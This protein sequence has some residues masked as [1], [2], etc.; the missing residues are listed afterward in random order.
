MDCIH[1]LAECEECGGLK[2]TTWTKLGD[3]ATVQ[4]DGGFTLGPGAVYIAPVDEPCP[5]TPSGGD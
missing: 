3:D 4:I 2:V 5:N 1:D